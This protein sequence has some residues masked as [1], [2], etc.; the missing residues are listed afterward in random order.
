MKLGRFKRF[1]FNAVLLALVGFTGLTMF[2]V[3]YRKA[4]DIPLGG[5]FSTDDKGSKRL[6]TFW[7]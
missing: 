7:P 3:A 6:A 2:E 4:R 5:R 1:C